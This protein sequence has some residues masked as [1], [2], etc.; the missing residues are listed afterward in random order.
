MGKGE[1]GKGKQDTMREREN[2]LEEREFEREIKK[3]GRWLGANDRY[4][5]Y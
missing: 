2:K 5:N 3:Q 4:S 1:K